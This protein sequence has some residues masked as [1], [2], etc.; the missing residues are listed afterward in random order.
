MHLKTAIQK[1]LNE[2][3]DCFFFPTKNT[4]CSLVGC[5]RGKLVCMLILETNRRP[6]KQEIS[7][8][9][10]ILQNGGEHYVIRTLEDV[11]EISK[12]KGWL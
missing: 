3:P 9:A 1:Y 4:K 8:S 6:N 7:F 5:V 2:L 12:A 11:C 10:R